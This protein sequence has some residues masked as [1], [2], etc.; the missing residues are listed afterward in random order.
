MVLVKLLNNSSW[1]KQIKSE[2]I[3]RNYEYFT[4][5]AHAYSQVPLRLRNLVADGGIPGTVIEQCAANYEQIRKDIL[6]QIQNTTQNSNDIVN[7]FQTKILN[8][9]VIATQNETIEK[10]VTEGII[11][12]NIPI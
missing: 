11:S 9:F 1:G 5:I 10:L 4:F 7:S 8:K 6:K 2:L 12:E 3:I